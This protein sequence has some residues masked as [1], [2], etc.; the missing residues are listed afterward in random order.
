M[1]ANKDGTR[2]PKKATEYAFSNIYIE[3]TTPLLVTTVSGATV[4]RATQK[5]RI[6]AERS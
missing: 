6:I 5:Q 2:S 4:Y 3:R 1:L